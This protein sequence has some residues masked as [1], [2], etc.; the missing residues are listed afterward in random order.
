LGYPRKPR[1]HDRKAVALVLRTGTA[2]P[3]G[4]AARLQEIATRLDPHLRVDQ[5]RRLGDVYQ[6]AHRDENIVQSRIGVLV[7]IVLLFSAAAIYTLTAF[8]LTQRCREISIRMAI[9]APSRRLLADILGRTLSPVVVG[10][11][12][13]ALLAGFSK[14]AWM[15]MWIAV[16]PQSASVQA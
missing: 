3:D 16:P 8:A 2:I 7:T 12:V 9:G 13:S 4:L 11:A 6:Q 10:A 15:R 1:D 14:S 5:L